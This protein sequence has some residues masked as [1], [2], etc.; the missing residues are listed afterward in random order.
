MSETKLLLPGG[1]GLPAD[2]VA[3]ALCPVKSTAVMAMVE[4]VPTKILLDAPCRRSCMWYLE[5]DGK[6][7]CAVTVLALA[8]G[9]RA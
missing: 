1:E 6:P 5:R 7:S 8:M 2:A 4:G 3:G 9:D